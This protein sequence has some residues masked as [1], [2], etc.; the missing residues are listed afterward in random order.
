MTEHEDILVQLREIRSKVD[1]VEESLHSV[2]TD[3]AVIKAVGDTVNKARL[4]QWL[5]IAIAC[6]MSLLSI[7]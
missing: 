7:F 2:M 5:G 4:S 6:L 1:K 3:V